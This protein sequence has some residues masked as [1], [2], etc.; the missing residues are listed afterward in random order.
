MHGL[1]LQ[2]RL[3][4]PELNLI[5]R[6]GVSIRVE[7]KAMDVLLALAKQPG[8]VVSKSHI[9]QSV[10]NGVFV[11]EDVVTNAISALR[12]A[13]GDETKSPA[14]I[15]T[16]PKRGYR[17]IA[18]PFQG[19]AVEDR[20]SISGD[21]S[22]SQVSY[23]VTDGLPED[24]GRSILRV[25]Y[26]RHEETVQSLNSARAYCEEII[27]QEPNCAAAY[28]ELALTLFLLEKLGVVGREEIEPRVR[29]AV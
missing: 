25:R 18:P 7:P 23:A 5:I 3:V 6:N 17:L 2:D 26:L 21:S 22:R 28:A 19:A 16:I 20:C 10:W 9:I 8:E 13:L 27:R 14:L 4:F 24:L 1:R 29:N 11:C 15:Q 12:R